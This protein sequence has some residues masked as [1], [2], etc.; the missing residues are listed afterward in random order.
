MNNCVKTNITK[1]NIKLNRYTLEMLQSSVFRDEWMGHNF[2]RS[3]ELH[4]QWEM[5]HDF[6]KSLRVFTSSGEVNTRELLG[7]MYLFSSWTEK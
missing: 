7:S 6:L 5:K 2:C 1:Y 4:P 3:P